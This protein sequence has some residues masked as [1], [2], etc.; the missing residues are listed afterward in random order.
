MYLYVNMYIMIHLCF[1]I[2]KSLKQSGEIVSPRDVAQKILNN[3]PSTPFVIE[4]VMY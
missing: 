2:L 4:K 1:F 3:L